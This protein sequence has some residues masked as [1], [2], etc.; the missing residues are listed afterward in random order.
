MH[1]ILRLGALSVALGVC[2]VASPLAA[3][4]ARA[5]SN[6]V[7]T[8]VEQFHAALTAGD[9]ARAVAML[10]N[11]VLVLESGAIQTRADYLSHHLGA[12]MKASKVSTA[13]RSVVQVRMM[14]DAAYV[15]TKTI[16]PPTAAEGST[17]SEL[18]ELMV[19]SRTGAGW[20]IRAVH[21]SS[22]RRRA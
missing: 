2:L 7:V 1:P 9:S 8:A 18:A 22:R 15:V 17:G 13:T 20:T 4:G 19:L 21:W 3:Q 5:D 6:A 16:T 11:D 14:G 10:S 12:D